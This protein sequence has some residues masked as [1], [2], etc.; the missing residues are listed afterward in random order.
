MSEQTPAEQ[1]EKILRDPAMFEY[2]AKGFFDDQPEEKRRGVT[3]DQFLVE[4]KLA[5]TQ[6]ARALHD[7]LANDLHF[8]A[9]LTVISHEHE[10]RLAHQRSVNA[11]LIEIERRL[12]IEGL[13]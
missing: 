4:L 9:L 8:A 11:R 2:V 7:E 12:G 5:E 10:A 3:F 1:V 6:E 13:T